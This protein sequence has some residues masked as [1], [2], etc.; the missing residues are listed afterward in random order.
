MLLVAKQ[1]KDEDSQWHL[2]D[3]KARVKELELKAHV[4]FDTRYIPD[5]EATVYFSAA[6]LVLVPYTESVG[7]SG[8]IHNF[9]SLGIPIIAANVGLRMLETLG[10]NLILFERETR[11]ILRT[12][13]YN[14]VRTQMQGRRLVGHDRLTQG[15]SHRSLQPGAQLSIITGLFNYECGLRC[16]EI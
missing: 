9:T 12:R 16:P 5:D 14:C 4:R 13:P 8:P 7:A 10:G 3:M 2:N 1:A 15:E 6:S 11:L